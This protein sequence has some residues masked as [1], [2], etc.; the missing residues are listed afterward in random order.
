MNADERLVERLE[1]VQ[2]FHRT[3]NSAHSHEYHAH[4]IAEAIDRLRA[5]P[6]HESGEVA[7]S[8]EMVD[9]FLSWP[10]PYDVVADACATIPMYPHRSGTNLLN[11]AQAEQMLKHVLAAERGAV[12]DSERYRLLCHLLDTEQVTDGL[13]EAF[14]LGATALSEWLDSAHL[15]RPEGKP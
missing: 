15:A 10:L 12:R 5:L 8:K 1:A 2:K 11:A 4:S 9:R 14:Q 13:H 3:G 7:V 6:Q